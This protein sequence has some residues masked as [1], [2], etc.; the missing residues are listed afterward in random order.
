V[1]WDI[2]R[3]IKIPWVKW[4]D[5]CRPKDGGVCVKDLKVFNLSLLA[6]WSGGCLWMGKPIGKMYC[7]RSMSWLVGRNWVLG[8][9]V[10]KALCSGRT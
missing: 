9:G 3:R 4:S 5:V 8:C 6:K 2:L 1:G 10:I 7:R